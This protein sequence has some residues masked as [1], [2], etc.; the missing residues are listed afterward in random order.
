MIEVSLFKSIKAYSSTGRVELLDWL[1]PSNMY[2][3]IV[4][5][6][7]NARAESERNRLKELLP[8]VTISC[9]CSNRQRE[10]I[11]SYTN[12]ICI[13]IDGKDNPSISNMEQLKVTLGQLPYVMYCSLSASGKGVFCI[14][15]YADWHHHKEHFYAL[16]E[17]FRQMGVV[18]DSSCSDICRLRFYSYD[19]KPYVNKK[20]EIYSKTSKRLSKVNKTQKTPEQS[21]QM[22]E[23][24]I[25]R[26]AKT[27]DGL[28][29]EDMLLQPSNLD[30]VN[31]FY[32]SPTDEVKRIV[33]Y[34][35]NRRI[36]ITNGYRAWRKIGLVIK[37]VYGKNGREQFHKV[38]QFYPTYTPEETNQLYDFIEEHGYPTEYSNIRKIAEKYIGSREISEILTG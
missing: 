30:A 6:L 16:E 4:K 24:K 12:L 15:R 34:V 37:Q 28:S 13:D 14:I 17:D 36:D 20:A 2:A 35:I 3:D 38:S 31:I 23:S 11:I 19:P 5:D 18:V 26:E 9:V 21:L 29:V 32:I 1:S 8:G 25:E 27:N 10:K 7:R 22:V 33:Q